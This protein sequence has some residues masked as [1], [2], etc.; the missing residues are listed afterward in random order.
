ML[1][2]DLV[3]GSVTGT[4]YCLF[5]KQ[6]S[7][8]PTVNPGLFNQTRRITGHNVSVTRYKSVIRNGHDWSPANIV[9][10]LVQNHFICVYAFSRNYKSVLLLLLYSLFHTP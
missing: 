8:I 9:L 1:E 5:Q 4:Y 7:N 3:S 2:G 6:I 10:S